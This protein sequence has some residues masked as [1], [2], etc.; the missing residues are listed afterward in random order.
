MLS[1][2]AAV[3]AASCAARLPPRP[4]GAAS[5][6]PDAAAHFDRA[7]AHCAGLRTATME[8]GLSGRAGDETVRGRVITGL[9]R[10]GAA[11]LEGL[12][13]FGA[14]LFILV[15]RAEQATLLLPRDRRVL[16]STPVAVVM[17]RLTGLALGADD[18]LQALTGCIG[19]GDAEGGRQWPGGWRAVSTEAG[20]T[21]FLRDREGT[22]AVVAVDAGAWRADYSEIVNAYLENW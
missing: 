19:A 9:E 8:L 6:S 22:W 18:L 5:A 16:A 11:R 7:T 3:V 12:A 10:G 21:I 15:A 2:T 14:P 1:V 4:S 17:E 13:P 20:S